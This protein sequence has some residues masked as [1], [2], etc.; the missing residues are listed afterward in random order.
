MS[1]I[2]P[3]L[4]AFYNLLANHDWYYEYSDDYSKWKRGKEQEKE[5]AE[6][7]EN[8]PEFHSVYETYKKDHL[9]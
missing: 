6:V 7:M 8:F 1:T 3:E 4:Q 5:I 9:G 2:N